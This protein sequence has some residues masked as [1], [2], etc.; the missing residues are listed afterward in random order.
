MMP[1]MVQP[2]DT[3]VVDQEALLR[4]HVGALEARAHAVEAKLYA[5]RQQDELRAKEKARRK[6][7]GGPTGS[8]FGEE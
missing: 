8:A 7:E 6:I 3:P 2:G 1:S 5:R 4:E